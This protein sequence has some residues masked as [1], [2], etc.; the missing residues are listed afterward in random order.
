MLSFLSSSREE[1]RE[2]TSS[3]H[4]RNCPLILIMLIDIYDKGDFL[5]KDQ[6]D[7]VG[8]GSYNVTRIFESSPIKEYKPN[9]IKRTEERQPS[10]DRNLF[11][12][13]ID[14][15]NKQMQKNRDLIN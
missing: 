9:E 10:V 1:K 4:D 2:R 14:Y 11:M 8:P 15:N 13:A 12:Q 6:N 3:I 7:V 5:P